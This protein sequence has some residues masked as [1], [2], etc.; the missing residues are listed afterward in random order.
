M[1]ALEAVGA[2]FYVFQVDDE[3]SHFQGALARDP[4]A[5]KQEELA[6]I[7]GT[8]RRF[9]FYRLTELGLTVGGAG[10]AVYGFASNRDAWKGL[11]LGITSVALPFLIIDTINNGRAARYLDDLGNFDPTLARSQSGPTLML[12]QTPWMFSYS[13]RF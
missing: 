13:G 7:Q 8:T 4:K 5:F 6:H 9:T 1:R 11:G 3:S 10:I 2:I 12:P